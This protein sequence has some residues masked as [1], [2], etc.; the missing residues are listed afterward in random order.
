LLKLSHL[1][2][3][4]VFLYAG[5][6]G[7]S[8]RVH[9]PVQLLVLGFL[10]V[11]V[12]KLLPG[13]AATIAADATPTTAAVAP[14]AFDRPPERVPSNAPPVTAETAALAPAEPRSNQCARLEFPA[15]PARLSCTR[16]MRLTTKSFHAPPL[17]VTIEN[18]CL[19]PIVQLVAI[20]PL[21]LWKW[22]P[23]LNLALTIHCGPL[24]RHQLV[25]S[26]EVLPALHLMVASSAPFLSALSLWSYEFRVLNFL[27]PKLLR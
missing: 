25:L 6:V 13:F 22:L 14:I 18:E 19:E 11:S 27:R 23:I 4:W 26:E 1:R 3:E 15:A 9:L 21:V 5:E 17:D 7:N 20:K 12:A 10:K 16:I 2:D 8:K 24:F